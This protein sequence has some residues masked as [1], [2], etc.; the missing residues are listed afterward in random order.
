MRTASSVSRGPISSPVTSSNFTSHPTVVTASETDGVEAQ[1]KEIYPERFYDK[2]RMQKLLCVQC[3]S[4]KMFQVRVRY[5]PID[6]NSQEAI[7]IQILSYQLHVS[8]KRIIALTRNEECIDTLVTA[9]LDRLSALDPE[10]PDYRFL[11]YRFAVTDAMDH[12]PDV[13]SF[14]ESEHGEGDAQ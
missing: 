11:Q 4:G 7:C 5:S 3:S 8:V 14:P 10:S 12:E 13:R 6:Y 2:H 1:P 9:E